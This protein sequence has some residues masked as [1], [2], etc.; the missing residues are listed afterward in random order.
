MKPMIIDPCQDKRWDDFVNQHPFGWL[1]HTSIWK[2]VLEKSFHH[3]KANYFVL[4]DKKTYDIRA[5]LPC[6]HVK[7]WL[8]GNRLVSLPFT[9]LSD[10]LVNSPD[11]FRM[12]MASAIDLS[13]KFKCRYMEIG[14]FQSGNCIENREISALKNYRVHHLTIDRDAEALKTRFK[15][16][17]R[18]SIRRAEAE[19]VHVSEGRGES[20]LSEFFTL[21]LKTRKR[22]LL[23]PQPYR[24]IR[25][26]WRE[27]HP[28]GYLTLLMARHNGQTI[29]SAILLKFKERLSVEFLVSDETS[30]HLRPNHIL[31]WNAIKMARKEGYGVFDFGRTASGNRGLIKFKKSWGAQDENLLHLYYP[32]EMCGNAARREDTLKY[33]LVK[34]VCHMA[35]P[36]F[37]Q[38]LGIFLYRHMG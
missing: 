25:T 34:K 7:S 9:T 4:I 22:R 15:R 17:V 37:F 14:V 30:F 10:P 29:G 5:A 3:I 1:Y 36:P 20:D 31:V 6:C 38:G 2:M 32:G 28:R 35:P 13:G 24:F 33:K 21:Y 27:L 11:E 16:T 26:I 23:P 12:L 19:A 8:T 18:Q